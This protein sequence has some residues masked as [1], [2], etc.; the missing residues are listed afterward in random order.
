ME[1]SVLSIFIVLALLSVG[2]LS[3]KFLPISLRQTLLKP[4]SAAVLLLLF[5]MGFEFGGVFTDPNLG[6]EIVRH[7]L[8]LALIIS[9]FTLLALYHKP[10]TPAV[11]APSGSFAK[12]FAGCFKA[13]AFFGLG[14]AAYYFSGWQADRLPVGSSHILYL[15]IFMVGMD[16]VHFQPRG[17]GR[18]IFL[19]PVLTVAA[20]AAACFVFSL[21]SPYSFS[22]SLVLAGGFGWFSL[23]GP[24]VGKAVSSEMGAAA[25]MTDFFREMVSI[26][27]LYFYGRRQPMAAIGISGAA[28]MDSA[29][30]FIKENCDSAYIK[31]A[32]VSGFILTLAAPLF[33]SLAVALLQ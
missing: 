27:F 15:L 20:T 6:A 24:M 33:L 21:C 1:S 22:Q 17:F 2:F 26:V 8:L 9:A 7:T 11:A 14:V 10:E 32:V 28:A 13:L 18:R 31:Y 16:L 4:L 12:P 25:F 30:P 3:G 29:L 19:L 5:F 23:S